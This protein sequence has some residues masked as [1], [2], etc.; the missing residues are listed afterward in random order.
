MN[1]PSSETT[2]GTLENAGSP[3]VEPTKKDESTET[4]PQESVEDKSETDRVLRLKQEVAQLQNKMS[5]M[6]PYAQLGQ[7][8]VND[9]DKG[10]TV[11]KRWQRGEKLF[12]DDSES[13]NMEDTK[14]P[15]TGPPGLTEESLGRILDQRDASHHEM[16]ELNSMAREELKHFD[17]ISKSPRYVQFL[18]NNMEGVWK[19]YI[20]Q[21]ADTLE[22]ADQGK[23]KNYSAVKQAYL[24]VLAASP[25]VISASK[26]AGKKETAERAEAALAASGSGGTSTSTTEEL[27]ERTDTEQMIDRMVNPSGRGKSFSSVARKK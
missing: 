3:E 25:E 16:D 22:W 7:A 5:Q 13:H 8:V 2:D 21:D 6:G 23:A 11:V 15:E 18:S 19:G 4:K 9:K 20:P 17:K 26:E 10:Q 1:N 24:Q 14:Q 27:P 12:I